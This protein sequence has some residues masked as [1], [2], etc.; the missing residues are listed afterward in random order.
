MERGEHDLINAKSKIEKLKHQLETDG[1]ERDALLERLKINN[2]TNEEA[3]K[4]NKKVNRE[5]FELS[6]VLLKTKE[7]VDAHEVEILELK[8][9]LDKAN[10]NSEEQHVNLD[11]LFEQ[12]DAL[13]LQLKDNEMDN[14]DKD[15]SIATLM[16]K[17]ENECIAREKEQQKYAV[18]LVS[19][20]DKV[21]I[22]R[23]EV[24][25]N[26]DKNDKTK[27]KEVLEAVRQVSLSLRFMFKGQFYY[28]VDFLFSYDVLLS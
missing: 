23:E 8:E 27:E 17:L 21:S 25:D 2:S 10:K 1:A 9:K 14:I 28:T 3:N 15:S 26:A 6:E 7:F 16:V 24:V 20:Q 11:T 22:A 19:L 5:L 18:D 13:E 12:K 4:E